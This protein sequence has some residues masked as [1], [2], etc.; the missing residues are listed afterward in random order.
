MQQIHV[1]HLS[2]IFL[3][4]WSNISE[5]S[6]NLSSCL[7]RCLRNPFWLCSSRCYRQRGSL[8]YMDRAAAVYWQKCKS[9]DCKTFESQTEMGQK[10]LGP[11]RWRDWRLKDLDVHKPQHGITVMAWPGWKRS[12]WTPEPGGLSERIPQFSIRLKLEINWQAVKCTCY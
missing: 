5:Y 1:D 2:K 6:A 11:P 9:G 4:S 10:H 8:L 3:N 7:V 12:E